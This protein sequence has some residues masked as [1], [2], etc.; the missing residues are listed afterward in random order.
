[1]PSHFGRHLVLTITLLILTASLSG[2]QDCD[3]ACL[4]TVLDQ[5]LNA[6]TKHDPAAAPLFVGF[7]QTE[8]A[9]VVKAGGGLWKTATGLGKVQR[10]YYDPVNGQAAFLGLIEESGAPAI[11]TLR[12]KV[13]NK[14]A[15]E[16][17]WVISRKGDPGLNGPAGG[18][19]FDVENLIKNPPPERI[20]PKQER[21]TRDAMIAVANSYFDGITTHDGSIIQ[22]YPGCP[23]IENGVTMTGR[24]AAPRGGGAGAPRG[25]APAAERDCTSG[26]ETINIQNVAARRFPVVDEEA[27]VV[28]AMA[29]FI[30]KPGIPTRRNMF[31]ESFVLDK[32]KISSIYATL[33]Y[34]PPEMPVPNWPPFDGNWPLPA[35]L[36]APPAR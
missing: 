27:G 10:R 21:M 34:P 12:L 20:L 29:V 13:S 15:S 30:R 18:N 6:L 22:A 35:A 1:M 26:L 32:H 4:R 5:Y 17:E 14:M 33:F 24:G 8:N 25:G 9:T 11:V 31:G 3:R 2:A 16:A 23:R 36:T 28:L 7:R 19:V